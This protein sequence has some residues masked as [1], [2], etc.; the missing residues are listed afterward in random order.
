MRANNFD[1]RMYLNYSWKSNENT[2]LNSW[3]LLNC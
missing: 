1:K 3:K 2:N